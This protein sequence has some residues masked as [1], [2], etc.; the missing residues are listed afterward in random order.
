MHM[1]PPVPDSVCKEEMWGAT[2]ENNVMIEYVTD[3]WGERLRN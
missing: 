2:T 1:N 3:T